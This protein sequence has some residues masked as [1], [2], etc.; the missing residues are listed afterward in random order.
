MTVVQFTRFRV[1]EDQTASLLAASR[2]ALESKPTQ[3]AGLR[4]VLL[5]RVDGGDW[6]DIAFWDDDGTADD[7]ESQ[8]LP[9]TRK[10]L[11]GRIEELLGEESGQVIF[12]SSSDSPL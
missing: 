2:T 9:R 11:F 6:L 1:R 5:V 8:T 4:Q 7:S 10:E 12:D 3:N